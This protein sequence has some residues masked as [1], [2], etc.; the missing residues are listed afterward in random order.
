M[1]GH[2]SHYTLHSKA[3]NHIKHELNFNFPFQLPKYGKPNNNPTLVRACK[4]G[5]R[6]R[7]TLVPFQQGAGVNKVSVRNVND[8]MP[9]GQGDIGTILLS[10][11]EDG[12][13]SDTLY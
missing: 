1:S 9:T 13:Y 5:E 3:C 10:P 8:L 7:G 2:I 4:G 11:F 6:E 12:H